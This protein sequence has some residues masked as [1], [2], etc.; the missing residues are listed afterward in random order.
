[1][2][3]ID[4]VMK[5]KSLKCYLPRFARWHWL[6]CGLWSKSIPYHNKLECLSQSAQSNN[7]GQDYAILESRKVKPY[8]QI[9]N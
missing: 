6:F 7:C 2:I 9:L 3:I 8:L 1:M 5:L 4:V